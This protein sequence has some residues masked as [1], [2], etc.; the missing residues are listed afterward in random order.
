M[1]HFSQFLSRNVSKKNC[2]LLLHFAVVSLMQVLASGELQFFK[3]SVAFM[4]CER[5]KKIIHNVLHLGLIC[6]STN[7]VRSSKFQWM[8]MINKSR[9]ETKRDEKSFKWN[10]KKNFKVFSPNTNTQ[11]SLGELND[12]PLSLILS[13]NKKLWYILKSNIN[14]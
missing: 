13:R 6:I 7:Q 1:P 12:F 8:M 11:K 10:R 2:F 9:N 3:L 14:P 5:G 4:K